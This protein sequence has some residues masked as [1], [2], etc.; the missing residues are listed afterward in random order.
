MPA[1]K[2]PYTHSLTSTHILIHSHIH[3]NTHRLTRTCTHIHTCTHAHTL[4]WTYSLTYTLKHIYIHAHT[5]TQIYTLTQGHTL[6]HMY[7][8]V[9]TQHTHSHRDQVFYTLAYSGHFSFKPA[10]WVAILLSEHPVS[11]SSCDYNTTQSAPRILSVT[12]I[13]RER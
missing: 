12:G 7:T 2:T 6:T 4:T 10:H 3:T 13:E 8:H 11:P 5:L 1:I 9:C